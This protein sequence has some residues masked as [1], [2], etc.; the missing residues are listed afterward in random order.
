[1][2][3]ELKALIF[4]VDGTLA[5]TERDGHLRACNDA[6]AELG[7]PVQWTWDEFRALLPIA[8]NAA[9]MSQALERQ[10]GLSTAER[11]AAVAELVRRKQAFYI[12][13]YLPNLP[14][15]P[16]VA[17]V[18]EQAIERGIRLAVVSTSREEQIHALLRARLPRAASVFDPVLGQAAGEKTSAESPLFRRCRDELGERYGIATEEMLAIED[19][20]M[21][22][23]AAVTAGLACAVFYNDYTFGQPFA[24]AR[25]VAPSL[26]H[27]DVD[28]LAAICLDQS[29]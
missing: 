12:E 27:F 18:I 9:R 20:A 28:D 13:R 23:G 16:G 8:G 3:A 1:M 2:R 5:D 26:A 4:D 14:L 15:R 22:L 29:T 7:L 25:L 21:G 11:E 19:S 24:G 6:F 10:T 17:R